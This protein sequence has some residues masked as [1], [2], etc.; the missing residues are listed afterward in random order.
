MAVGSLTLAF[1]RG[2]RMRQL[3]FESD[4]NFRLQIDPRRLISNLILKVMTHNGRW[5]A[6]ASV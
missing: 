6:H 5:L 4:G 2:N 3:F 1:D